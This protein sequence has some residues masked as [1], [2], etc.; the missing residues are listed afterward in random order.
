MLVRVLARAATVRVGPSGTVC[1]VDVNLG[2]LAI[3][4]RTEPCM[5]WLQ[6][7][8]K[9]LPLSDS[10]VDHVCFASSG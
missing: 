6:G 9:S 2:M 7:H 5:R 4:A 8:A 10:S 1:G 3:A